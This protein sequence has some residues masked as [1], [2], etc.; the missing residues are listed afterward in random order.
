[1]LCHKHANLLYDTYVDSLE[2]F[3]ETQGSVPAEFEKEKDDTPASVVYL[4]ET[5]RVTFDSSII[6]KLFD[7]HSGKFCTFNKSPLNL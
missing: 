6:Q 7:L 1:M 5:F 2:I 3:F 4:H